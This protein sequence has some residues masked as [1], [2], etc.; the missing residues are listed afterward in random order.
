MKQSLP[1]VARFY[2]IPLHCDR[3]TYKLEFRL[4]NHFEKSVYMIL[5]SVQGVPFCID[6]THPNPA[7]K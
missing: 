2:K 7:D 4:L 5:T 3:S 6:G 1:F